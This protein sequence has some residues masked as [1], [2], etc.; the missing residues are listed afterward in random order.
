MN[1][2][3]LIASL[4]GLAFSVYAIF[5]PHWPNGAAVRLIWSGAKLTRCPHGAGAWLIVAYGDVRCLRCEKSRPG[6]PNSAR[7]V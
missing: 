7:F 1:Y 2:A 6:R 4:T 5:R 3:L